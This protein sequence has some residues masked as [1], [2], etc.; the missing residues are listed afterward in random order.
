MSQW[1]WLL[2]TRDSPRLH[3]TQTL[4]Q[5]MGLLSASSL[6]QVYLKEPQSPLG[7]HCQ[8]EA[9]Q[10]KGRKEK[11]PEERG[12][13]GVT[14][15]FPQFL[16]S[17]DPSSEK[18]HSKAWQ[19]W[20]WQSYY[21]VY[22]FCSQRKRTASDLSFNHSRV[23]VAKC[24]PERWCWARECLTSLSGPVSWRVTKW[25][26]EDIYLLQSRQLPSR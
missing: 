3:S 8:G 21:P 22:P 9:K 5:V 20:E 18:P 17:Q 13:Y 10:S 6:S 12:R 11:Q 7:P 4:P 24:Q 2:I 19:G 16:S 23:S 25:G 26:L 15:Q 1:K 14:T